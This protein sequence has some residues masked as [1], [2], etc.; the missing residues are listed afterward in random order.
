M[1]DRNKS[2]ATALNNTEVAS[3]AGSS[4]LLVRE[5]CRTTPVYKV[6]CI[7][8]NSSPIYLF[9]VNKIRFK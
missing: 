8:S 5:I 9:S 3:A 1:S 4:P 7:R 2:R 6:G